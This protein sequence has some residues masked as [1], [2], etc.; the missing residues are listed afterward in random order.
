MGSH[1]MVATMHTL[2]V[3][4]LA[5]KTADMGPQFDIGKIFQALYKPPNPENKPQKRI[6]T[7]YQDC[8][9]LG[10][11][12]YS[13]R[14]NSCM[15][16]CEWKTNPYYKFYVPWD[17]FELNRFDDCIRTEQ[18]NVLLTAPKVPKQLSCLKSCFQRL[19]CRRLQGTAN[20]LLC[21]DEE[22]GFFLESISPNIDCII[23]SH[24]DI[25]DGLLPENINI[26]LEEVGVNPF[27]RCDKPN[28]NRTNSAKR[29]V[30]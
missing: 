20:G 18:I 23:K 24:L 3:L 1:T 29:F 9:E 12:S 17:F 25:T 27:P 22:Q 15:R 28:C 4:F 16:T 10:E 11:D 6:L 19:Q 21:P 7:D 13:N 5:I 26:E 14:D 30:N 8:V 2:L